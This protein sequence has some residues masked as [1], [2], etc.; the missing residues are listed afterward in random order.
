MKEFYDI[1]DGIESIKS[2]F[3]TD[4]ERLDQATHIFAYYNYEDYSGDAYVLFKV[5]DQWYQNGGGH[6]SCN[7]LE[8]QWEPEETTLEAV[9]N[10]N[11]Y[12]NLQEFIAK[13][14]GTN[15]N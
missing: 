1:F 12:T 2:Q 13:V 15:E 11:A 7:G 5:G 8:G 6:C 4:D 14:E 9:K 10:Y 3:E